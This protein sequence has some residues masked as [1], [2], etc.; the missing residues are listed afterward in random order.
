MLICYSCILLD[1]M[2]V[3]SFAHCFLIGLFPLLIVRVL[4]IFWIQVLK[5][6]DVQI[7][8][9]EACIF[10]FLLLSFKEQMLN[11][12]MFIFSFSFVVH[13]FHFVS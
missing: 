13:A 6:E 12:I 1:E 2:S 10:I 9:S 7:P 3:I 4:W 11:V 5:Y 8:K